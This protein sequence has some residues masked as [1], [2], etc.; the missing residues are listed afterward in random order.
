MPTELQAGKINVSSSKKFLLVSIVMA[1]VII[2][3]QL[4]PSDDAYFTDKAR[5]HE[6][7]CPN[8][9]EWGRWDEAI[10]MRWRKINEGRMSFGEE[11]C[12][13]R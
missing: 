7:R 11:G 1:L 3:A 4:L 8:P 6:V 10:K 9:G 12:Y 2:C 13:R 5:W